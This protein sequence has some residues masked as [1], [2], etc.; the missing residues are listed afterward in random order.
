MTATCWVNGSYYLR[1]S[2]HA[3]TVT[4]GLKPLSGQLIDADAAAAF[5]Q[6]VRDQ[7]HEFFATAQS[8]PLWRVSHHRQRPYQ[9]VL[10]TCCW[11]GRADC[12]G[13]ATMMLTLCRTTL[14]KSAAGAGRCEAQLQ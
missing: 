8:K 2:G 4:Q 6:K 7:Q 13:C 3:G 9:T 10:A 5:W 1:L 11:N 14:D 12:V